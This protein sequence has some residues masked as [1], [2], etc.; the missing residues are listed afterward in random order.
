MVR[1][2]NPM[3][4]TM[5]RVLLIVGLLIAAQAIAGR[6]IKAKLKPMLEDTRWKEAIADYKRARERGAP[7]VELEQK[8]REIGR[9]FKEL[10]SEHL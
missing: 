1:R 9:V 3:K 8:K 2:V 4:K 7:E 10:R 5:L 6:I